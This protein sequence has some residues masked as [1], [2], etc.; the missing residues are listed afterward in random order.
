MI[1]IDVKRSRDHI[2]V[3]CVGHTNYNTVGQDI[4]CAA[5]SSLLQTLCYS[6]EELTQR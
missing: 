2:A 4:V 3:S 1:K 6:L 5:I